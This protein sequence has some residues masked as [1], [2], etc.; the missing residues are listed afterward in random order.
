[1]RRHRAVHAG[2][3]KGT[4]GQGYKD[5]RSRDRYRFQIALSPCRIGTC[6]G[7]T[8]YETMIISFHLGAVVA[9]SVFVLYF[10]ANLEDPES[11]HTSLNAQIS[12]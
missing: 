4:G 2:D 8:T 1:M 9:M 7:T 11:I 3:G 5:A 10:Q 6:R 12:R